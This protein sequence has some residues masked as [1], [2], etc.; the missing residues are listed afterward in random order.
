MLVGGSQARKPP[1]QYELPSASAQSEPAGQQRPARHVPPQQST[2]DAHVVSS[3]TQTPHWQN[4]PGGQQTSPHISS[5]AQHAPPAQTSPKAQQVSTPS[6]DT[7]IISGAQQ[8]QLPFAATKGSS[9]APPQQTWS[10]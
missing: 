9:Q 2:S 3:A 8:D 7:Q 6:S 10:A 1:Q 5:G 4:C